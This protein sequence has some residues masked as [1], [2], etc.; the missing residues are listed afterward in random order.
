MRKSVPIDPKESFT[1]KRKALKIANRTLK[2]LISELGYTLKGEDDRLTK[3]SGE[4]VFI[5]GDCSTRYIYIQ[6]KSIMDY[7]R[8][9]ASNPDHIMWERVMMKA[10]ALKPHP[11]PQQHGEKQIVLEPKALIFT[12]KTP[13]SRVKKLHAQLVAG[14]FA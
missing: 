4:I 1:R 11:Q 2:L 3:P 9:R 14:L 7:D 5:W 12:G 13:V 10:T 8:R 6:F